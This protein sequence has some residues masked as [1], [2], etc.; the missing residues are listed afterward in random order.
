M[1]L[2]VLTLLGSRGID[3]ASSA[4]RPTTLLLGSGGPLE[5]LSMGGAAKTLNAGR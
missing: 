1:V 3:D 5:K 2:V 4:P